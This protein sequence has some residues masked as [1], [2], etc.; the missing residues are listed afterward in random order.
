[1]PPRRRHRNKPT[2]SHVDPHLAQFNALLA[3][4]ARRVADERRAER[5]ARKLAREQERHDAHGR[6]LADTRKAAATRL[7][8]AA[9]GADRVAAE[10]A[11]RAAAAAVVEFETGEWPS[12]APQLKDQLDDADP[13]AP[14]SDFDDNDDVEGNENSSS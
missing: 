14:D 10:L 11:W 5:E 12:W 4:D 7:K 1:M 8:T 2:S 6:A 13:S 9:R 3:A